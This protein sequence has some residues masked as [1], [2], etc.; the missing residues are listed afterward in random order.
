MAIREKAFQFQALNSNRYGLTLM[1]LSAF[2]GS[3]IPLFSKLSS[4]NPYQ[5]ISF[6]GLVQFILNY[7]TMKKIKVPF[8]YKSKLTNLKFYIRSLIG[9]CTF[10]CVLTATQKLSISEAMSIIFTNPILTGILGAIFQGEPFK[11]LEII[12][13]IFGLLGIV[14]IFKPPVVID[15]IGLSFLLEESQ[16]VVRDLNQVFLGRICA[17]LAVFFMSL[18]FLI[19]RSFSQGEQISS[20]APSQY[21]ATASVLVPCL[22]MIQFGVQMPGVFD[23]FCLVM[24]GI[25]Q[26]FNQI[27]MQE[28]LKNIKAGKGAVV[29]YTQILYSLLFDIF[30]FKSKIDM[31][32]LLGITSILTS[33]G[34]LFYKNWV[35]EI[36][37][38]GTTRQYKFSNLS[39]QSIISLK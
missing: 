10:T 15:T 7:Y 28:G 34:F 20:I 8:Y 39:R 5:C 36:G 23:V 16:L 29:N 12:V 9:V 1:F 25:L 21:F 33:A 24:Q 14:L 2:V 22:F 38:D 18:I 13:S 27:F 3:M 19:M 31:L 17:L 4:L 6:C 26:F 32:T 37:S 11:L 30:I 35:Q